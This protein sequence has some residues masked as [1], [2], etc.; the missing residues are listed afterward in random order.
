[1]DPVTYD[2]IPVRALHAAALAH[3]AGDHPP[4]FCD[5]CVRY[6]NAVQ[7]GLSYAKGTGLDPLVDLGF[8][9]G[10]HRSP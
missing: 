5:V 1:M 10:R 3:L 8:Y 4:G 6:M 7:D 9:A 2:R